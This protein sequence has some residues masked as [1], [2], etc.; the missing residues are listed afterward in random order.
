MNTPNEL[1]SAALVYAARGWPVIPLH[2]VN[3]GRCS[4]GKPDC[5]SPGKHPRTRNGLKDASCDPE[6]LAEWWRLWPDANVGIA[7]GASAGIVV[8]DVDPRHGG[9]ESWAALVQERGGAST[10]TAQTGGGGKHFIFHHPGGKLGNRANIRPGID[11]R[12]DGGYIVAPPS[13]HVSGG[14]YFWPEGWRQWAPGPLP[15]WLHVLL[16]RAEPP[17]TATAKEKGNDNGRTSVA[18][19]WQDAVAYVASAAGVGEGQRNSGAFS[20][21][22]HLAAFVTD[23]GLRLSEPQII[24]LVALWNGKNTP[25]LNENELTKAVRSALSNGT[26]RSA[27]AVHTKPLAAA[28]RGSGGKCEPPKLSPAEPYRP[29]PLAALPEPVRRFVEA[30]AAATGTDPAF[31]ALAAL[32]T[33]S[34]CIGNRAAAL[35]KAGWVEP[36][37][38]WG[39]LVGR[40]STTKSPV[41]KLVT[42][43]LFEL[44]KAERAAYAEELNEHGREMERYEVELSKWKGEQKKGNISD[45]PEPPEPPREKRVV[46]SD[47]TVE[48][49]GCLLQDNPLGLLVVRDE[50]AAWIGSFDRYAAGGKGSDCPAWLSMYDAAPVVIDRK[51]TAGT[52]FCERAAVSV[53][54]SIQPGTLARVFGTAEREAGLLGRV[55]LA[56]P[57]ER[58]ALWTDDALPDNAAAEWRALLSGLL[59][60]E[61]A[62]DDDSNPR[63]RCLP[64]SD[65]AKTLWVEWHNR[66]ARETADVDGDDLA[67]HFGKLKGACVRFALIFECV[68]VATGAGG[69]ASIESD[70][71][72]RAIAVA[73]WFK[74]EARRLY[75]QLADS[76]EERAARRLVDSIARKGGAVTVRDWQRAR[77]HPTAEA[78]E[79]ELAGLVAAGVGTWVHDPPGPKGGHPAKRFVLTAGHASEG[80][81]TDTTPADDPENGGSVS[82]SCVRAAEGEPPESRADTP[83]DDREG[84]EWGAV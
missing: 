18:Q 57:P 13:G 72:R 42:R 7:T 78:A 36:A 33:L 26:P 20:L 71:M 37:V 30:V 59:A 25:P 38:L 84:G 1:L 83:A 28:R 43:P 79:A 3:R 5:S 27:H 56:Y 77:S 75:G 55:L 4:C 6:A 68:A 41:L 35:V 9:N 23:D 45:P 63:P 15:E 10:L 40:S 19:L 32:V 66:H 73:E 50:L 34:G 49:L 48:K 14:W 52:I 16:T 31:A 44:Y 29:F 60:I 53:L 65:D 39:A 11:V 21:A 51:S 82:V 47:I 12:G 80:T 62:I 69:R 58:P 22:G 46:V 70:S 76:D 74:H 61:P 24:E 67:A 2:S 8:I 54:G 81:D 17:P 64:I